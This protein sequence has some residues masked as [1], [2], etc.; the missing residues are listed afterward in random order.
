MPLTSSASL[1][2]N[3]ETCSRK[4]YWSIWESWKLQ[5]KEILLRA[6]NVA[7]TAQESPDGAFGETAGAE[8]MQLAEDRG[9]DTE[10]F[11]V[12]DEVCHLACLAD[13]LTSAIRKPKDEPWLIPEPLQ[14]WKSE[15][16]LSPD[17]RNLR[18][19][20]LV[21]HWTDARH[22]SECRSWFTLGE[23]AHYKLPMQMV[24]LV[25][26]Q[27]RAGKYHSPW[28]QGYQHP[29]NKQL[30]FRKRSAGSRAEGNAFNDKWGK[31]WREDHA[32]ISRETWL[33]SMLT[34]DILR[35]VCFKVDVPVPP[36]EQCKKIR[37]MAKR[38]MDRLA[39]LTE[40]PEANLSS[41]DWPTP[42]VFRRLCHTIPEREPSERNGFVSVL[43]LEPSCST[44]SLP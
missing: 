16:F 4:G 42:C 2:T 24:V 9:L 37:D 12:Y 29:A 15:C 43:S 25:L 8:I 35:D 31:I 38:K 3:L 18:R 23:Q 20:V 14:N 36:A 11:Q 27:K 44:Q 32:E 13:I 1:L 40:K 30:R 6:L 41:C 33:Q 5:P 10:S 26:G 21:S 28:C 34:D 22:Y 7:L 19:I 39:K 17:G